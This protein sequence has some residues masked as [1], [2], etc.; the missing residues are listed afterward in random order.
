MAM[1]RIQFQ[2]GL[3][4]PAFLGQFGT[5]AQCK[6]AL[7][8]SRWRKAFVVQNAAESLRVKGREAQDIPM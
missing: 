2:A 1:S 4:L 7:K 8:V 6:A 5:K 3:S